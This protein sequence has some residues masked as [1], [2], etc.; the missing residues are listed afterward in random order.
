M[1]LTITILSRIHSDG[2]MRLERRLLISKLWEQRQCRWECPSKIRYLASWVPSFRCGIKQL[3]AMQMGYGLVHDY[4]LAKLA[5]YI[6]VVSLILVHCVQFAAITNIWQLDRCSFIASS[7][8]CTKSSSSSLEFWNT[9]AEDELMP[10]DSSPYEIETCQLVM[11]RC[12][13]TMIMWT[14]IASRWE[15]SDSSVSRIWAVW[16]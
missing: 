16:E 12:N 14:S 15:F 5:F 1:L 10:H 7:E 11:C 9:A 13:A 4:K 8:V 6:A 2:A 3:L